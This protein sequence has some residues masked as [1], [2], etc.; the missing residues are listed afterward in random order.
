MI[1]VLITGADG[2]VGRAVC[3]SLVKNGHHVIAGTRLGKTVGGA[4]EMRRLGDLGHASEVDSLVAGTD[5]IVHLAARVHVM[6]DRTADPLAEFR[7]VNVEG[8][9]ALAEAAERGGVKRLIFLSTVKINGEVTTGQPF[10]ESAAPNPQDSYGKSKWEAEQLLAN[11]GARGQL[12]TVTLRVPLVYGPGVKANFLSLLKLC[13]TNIPLPFGAL[14]DNKRSLIYVHNLADAIAEA[15]VNKVAAGKTFL[16]SDGAPVS[17]A[18]LVNTMR[19]ALERPARLWSISPRLL[20][21]TLSLVGKAS[22]AERLA[23]SL[24]VSSDA[25]IKHMGWRPPWSLQAGIS[26]TV[27]W[28]RGATAEKGNSR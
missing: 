1:R 27:S 14:T 16:V 24:E 5:A 4:H 23:G 6:N 3:A 12:E 7:R 26:E 20:R 10:S 18:A 25:I 8:T 22:A 21:G 28:Y 15:L 17:T 9:R 19:A 2:F 11:V 13:D